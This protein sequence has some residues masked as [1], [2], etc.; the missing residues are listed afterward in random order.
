[1]N[2]TTL[3]SIVRWLPVSTA[4]GLSL[5]ALAV[6]ALF[7]LYAPHTGIPDSQAPLGNLFGVARSYLYRNS[8]KNSV[9][10]MAAV[11]ILV[12]YLANTIARRAS[13]AQVSNRWLFALMVTPL[14]LP[15]PVAAWL[16]QWLFQQIDSV[17]YPQLA[18]SAVAL[19]QLWRLWPLA[20]LLA[21]LTAHVGARR[22]AV[23]AALAALWLAFAEVGVPLVATGGEPFNETHLWSTWA[24]HTLWVSRMWG[25]GAVMLGGTAV[26]GATLGALIWLI[27]ARAGALAR[28]P[29]T[30]SASPFM[31]GILTTGALV[32]LLPGLITL[33]SLAAQPSAHLLSNLSQSGYWRW[34]ANTLFVFVLAI[35]TAGA[36]V[37]PLHKKPSNRLS[38]ISG[39]SLMVGLSTA[40]LWYWIALRWIHGLAGIHALLVVGI[41]SGISS[42]LIAL[43][44]ADLVE[45]GGN[46]G[47]RKLRAL[48]VVIITAAIVV[49]SQFALGIAVTDGR[50]WHMVGP[51]ISL[52][53]AGAIWSRPALSAASLLT[54]SLTY[55]A[56][57]GITVLCAD[58]LDEPLAHDERTP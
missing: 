20:I 13:G 31:T 26:L 33:A 25:Y 45:P 21:P 19:V 43:W 55:V 9:L 54:F 36:I 14:F 47:R 34:I 53:L 1:M 16:W 3:A 23:I 35:L 57:L 28:M 38:T 56:A 58:R 39:L 10:V 42:G 48:S 4:L 2:R 51:G 41:V 27:L 12:Y 52:Y 17:S 6:A 37:L 24:F 40:S 50:A 18:L 46:L 49:A 8:L 11:G 32:A 30:Q 5:I 15:T 29:R 22:T 7:A 44:P